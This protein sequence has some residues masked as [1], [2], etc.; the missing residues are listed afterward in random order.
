MRSIYTAMS[1]GLNIGVWLLGGTY[2]VVFCIALWP[3]IS[4]NNNWL[5][6]MLLFG[7]TMGA[8]LCGAYLGAISGGAVHLCRNKRPRTAGRLCLYGSGVF[9]AAVWI[10]W[11]FASGSHGGITGIAIL[12]SG[13]WVWVAVLIWHGF[14]L[15][16][17]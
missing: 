10:F 12:F 3:E 11:T 17:C 5:A 1:I 2:F 14:R 15:L 16:R 4:R 8:A 6:F 7:I 13:A 9:T